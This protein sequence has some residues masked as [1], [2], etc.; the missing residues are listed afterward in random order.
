M[1]HNKKRATPATTQNAFICALVGG[2]I[3]LAVMLI[4]ALAFPL[5]ALKF[6]D[7]NASAMPISYI[8][9]FIGALI[10]A[11]AAAK[12]CGHSSVQT[13]LMSGAV[14]LL[15]MILVSLVIPG[16]GSIISALIIGAVIMG[17]SFLGSF[18]NMKLSGN[19]KRNM[20]KA[21]KRR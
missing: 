13:G 9:A 21:M 20:K 2:G 4:A 17:A 11:F 10:G 1:E 7:P 12:K 3:S 6:E 5:A 15:P 16:G 19:R 14:M 8:C 18:V